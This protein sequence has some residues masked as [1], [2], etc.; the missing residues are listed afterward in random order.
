MNTITKLPKHNHEWRLVKMMFIKPRDKVFQQLE[1]YCIH[2][3][4]IKE[5]TYE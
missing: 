2:C 1:F 5:I 3:L 4:K